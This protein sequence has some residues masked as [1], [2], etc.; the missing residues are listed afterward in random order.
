MIRL[1]ADDGHH[2]LLLMYILGSNLYFILFRQLTWIA[3]LEKFQDF[4]VFQVFILSA[5]SSETKRRKAN[6]FR[7]E[8]YCTHQKFL[9]TRI[10]LLFSY[11]LRLPRHHRKHTNLWHIY[12]LLNNNTI[13]IIL[14]L[15]L[16]VYNITTMLKE[17]AI[18]IHTKFPQP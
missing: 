12:M 10:I 11:L 7:S 8:N 2:C 3:F 5:C 17:P 16:L 4:Q 15:E 13:D 6:V 14:V 9:P 18:S 1:F